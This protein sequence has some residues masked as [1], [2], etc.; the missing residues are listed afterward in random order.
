MWK[1]AVEVLLDRELGAGLG[2]IECGAAA[3]HLVDPREHERDAFAHVAD[4]DLQRREP[5]EHTGQDQA[6]GVQADLDVPAPSGRGQHE[7]DVVVEPRVVGVVDR[8]G[9]GIGCR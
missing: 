4:D 6:H 1:F 5:V 3:E 2:R 8:L 9:G 7:A